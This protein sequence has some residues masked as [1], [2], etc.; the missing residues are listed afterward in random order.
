[1]KRGYRVRVLD[2]LSLGRRE[3]TPPD[4]EFIQGDVR[5]LETCRE[6]VRGCVGVFHLAAMS[7]S[8]ASLD[9][10]EI[11][12]SNNVIGT[13]NVLTAAREANV[14]KV[15]YSGSSTAYGNRPAPHTEDLRPEFLNFYGLSKYI[16]EE[17][18]LMFDRLYGLPGVVLRY[19]NVYGPRLSGTGPYALVLSIFL[20]QYRR[21]V[22]LTIHGSGEQRRDFVHVRDVARANVLA[23]ERDV[24]GTVLNVGSGTSV[25]IKEIATEIS[26]QHIFEPRRACDA[27]ITLADLNRVRRALGWQP[28]VSLQEGLRELLETVEQPVGA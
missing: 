22:P 11:C 27:E 5:D 21:G 23:F 17:Y 10:V 9:N 4:A 7:R 26:T 14:R 2:N 12:T 15:V 6:A 3:W 25:S 16:G 1:M 19:F 18:C 24:R 13:Q 8:A 20:E 28:E